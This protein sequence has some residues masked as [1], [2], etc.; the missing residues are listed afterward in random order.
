MVQLYRPVAIFTKAMTQDVHISFPRLPMKHSQHETIVPLWLELPVLPARKVISA[1]QVHKV[2]KLLLWDTQVLSRM[3]SE[4][5]AAPSDV[6]LGPDHVAG[7]VIE[8]QVYQ[9]S[10]WI[11]LGA[12]KH[13]FAV[14]PALTGSESDFP[15]YTSQQTSSVFTYHGC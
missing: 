11:S 13:M 3:V 10:F 15:A 12:Q 1:K 5:V 2:S 9:G 4:P 6:L 8:E 14:A 7:V